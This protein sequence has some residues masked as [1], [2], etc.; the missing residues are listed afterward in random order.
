MQRALPLI[1]AFLLIG[2]GEEAAQKQTQTQETKQEVVQTETP[3]EVVKPEEP[4]EVAQTQTPKEAVAQNVVQE[5]KQPEPVVAAKEAQPA[6]VAVQKDGTTLYKACASCHGA[7]ASKSALNK[8]QIIKGWSAQK[9]A[10][11][12]TGYKNGTYGGASKALMLG[13]VK[14]LSEADIKILSEHIA[15]F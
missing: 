11:A 6:E 12:L 7:D 2:C 14:N 10:D 1:A 8:S 4:K 15:K 5:P 9:I 13:Q 3:K